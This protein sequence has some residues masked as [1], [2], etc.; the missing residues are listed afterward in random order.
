MDRPVQF[1]LDADADGT[2][3]HT[4][5]PTP[6]TRSLSIKWLHVT[7]VTLYS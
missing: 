4:P 1:S 5:P 2:M 3:S 6:L 7:H